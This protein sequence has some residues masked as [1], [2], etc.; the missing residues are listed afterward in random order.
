MGHRPPLQ[1][2]LPRE[3][4]ES[5]ILQTSLEGTL[6]SRCVEHTAHTLHSPEPRAPAR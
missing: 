3:G 1:V 6:G 4:C 5:G 2:A